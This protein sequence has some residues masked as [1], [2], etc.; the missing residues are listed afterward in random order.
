[1]AIST[2]RSLGPLSNFFAHSSSYF[3]RLPAKLFNFFIRRPERLLATD[4]LLGMEIV[5]GLACFGLDE[6]TFPSCSPCVECTNH[7][8]S[9][10][11]SFRRVEICGRI[12]FSLSLSRLRTIERRIRD[13][14]RSFRPDDL[15]REFS[16][17]KEFQEFFSK[18]ITRFFFHKSVIIF[19]FNLLKADKMYIQV[20]T[21]FK[22]RYIYPTF[23]FIYR[24]LATFPSQ[25]SWSFFN[26]D[27]ILEHEDTS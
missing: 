9:L 26:L 2:H 25:L 6:K 8:L 21:T 19:W 10:G 15:Y 14:C 12:F 13:N 4:H 1:M 5:T 23:D 11:T 17:I 27:S 24:Q 22:H 7:L 18:L 3:P 16:L 20:C